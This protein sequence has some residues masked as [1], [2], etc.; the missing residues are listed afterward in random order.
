MVRAVEPA[1]PL[2]NSGI[3]A[4]GMVGRGQRQNTRVP[5]EPVQLVQEL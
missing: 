3:E 5:G 2:E 4:L 1:G